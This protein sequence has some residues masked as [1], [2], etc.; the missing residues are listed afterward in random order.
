MLPIYYDLHHKDFVEDLPY[1]RGIAARQAQPV[2]ELGC[3][4]GRVLLDLV[5]AGIQV[6][7]LDHDPAMLNLLRTKIERDNFQSVELVEAD[8]RN[9]D[10]E[11]KYGAIILPCNTYSTLSPP[12]RQASLTST[13]RHLTP[14]GV[15]AASM[16]NPYI[17]NALDEIGE[18]ELELIL[19]HPDSGNPVQVSSAWQKEG[20]RIRIDW[21]YDEL[22]PNGDVR[23]ETITTTHYAASSEELIEEWEAAGF[24]VSSLGNFE[25]GEFDEESSYLILEGILKGR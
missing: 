3:G 5:R 20:T 9:Y 4:T 25:G 10:L 2:L 15:F 1:W 21:R 6:S 23:R 12:E 17:L 19:E 22:L 8:L 7:G 16:P 13:S 18:G 14:G 24:A 11:E